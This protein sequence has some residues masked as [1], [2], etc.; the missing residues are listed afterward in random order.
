M[1]FSFSS[2]PMRIAGALAMGGLFLLSHCVRWQH[3]QYQAPPSAITDEQA[4]DDICGHP[5]ACASMA[6]IIKQFSTISQQNAD[7]APPA[8]GHS[9]SGG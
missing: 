3:D 1:A 6:K 7:P 8:N 4:Y 5:D 9:A 2:R